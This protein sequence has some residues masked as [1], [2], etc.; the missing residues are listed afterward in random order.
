M[1]KL[2]ESQMGDRA[3]YSHQANSSFGIPFDILGLKRKTLT[4]DEWPML[5][6]KAPFQSFKRIRS[7]ELYIVEADCDRVGE[8][9]FLAALLE[10]S[11]TSWLSST[12][13]H[14]V[15][16]P[17]PVEESIAKEFGSFLEYTKNL[18]IVNQDSELIKNQ[19][20]RSKAQVEKV[21]I[22]SLKNYKVSKT[23]SEFLIGDKTY[24]FSFLLPRETYYQIQSLLKLLS[25]LNIPFDQSFKNFTLPPGR[26]SI[27][28]GVKNTTI[29]D[30]S[31]NADL[32][33]IKVM[34]NMFKEI[35]GKKWVVLGD[36]VE[37]GQLERKEH[38]K[39]AEALNK[40]KMD[41]II[42][43]GPRLS[44]YTYPKLDPKITE[45]FIQPKDVLDYLKKNLE[46]GEFLLFKGARF[47]EGVIEHLLKNQSDESK[48]CRREKVWVERRRKW[49]L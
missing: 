23:G 9:E 3:E 41:K 33:S 21:S 35:E 5:F 47:L 13:T 15:N 29:L 46:G 31:Y 6:L 12:R 28:T 38:E 27:F 7:E 19:F 45:K 39:L 44:Q 2:L 42:L 8:G 14:S 17:K 49:G 25:Y 34:L 40:L 16:F 24:H 37:Q 32:E 11:V 36:M 30:S 48:L 20:Q 10:P 18:V 4:L 1:L 26:C 43:V 22:K